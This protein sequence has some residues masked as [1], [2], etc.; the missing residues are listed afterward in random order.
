[1]SRYIPARCYEKPPTGGTVVV[2]ETQRIAAAQRL[3]ASAA[4]PA[5]PKC[6]KCNTRM[7]RRTARATDRTF[8]GCQSWPRCNGTRSTNPVGHAAR[9]SRAIEGASP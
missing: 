7:V 5:V 8:W 9:H 6:P 2:T 3:A 1:M 4:L